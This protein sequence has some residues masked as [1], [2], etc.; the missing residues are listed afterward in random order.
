MTA[1]LDTIRVVASELSHQA[2]AK[3]ASGEWDEFCK[4]IIIRSVNEVKDNPDS[5][6]GRCVDHASLACTA[7]SPAP[8]PPRW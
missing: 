8:L 1:C 7:T 2:E 3:G 6:V 5:M 4:R